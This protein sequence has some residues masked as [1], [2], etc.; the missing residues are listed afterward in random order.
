MQFNRIPTT[1]KI[2]AIPINSGGSHLEPLNREKLRKYE[3]I[4]QTAKCCVFEQFH[5]T[6]LSLHL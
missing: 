1:L 4:N 3:S 5:N 6:R 2:K